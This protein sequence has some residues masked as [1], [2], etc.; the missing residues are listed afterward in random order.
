VRSTAGRFS[1]SQGLLYFAISLAFAYTAVF[2]VIRYLGFNAEMLDLGH[3][4]QAIWSATQGQ[5][6]V[7]TYINGPASDLAKQ[8]EFIYFLLVPFYALLPSPI[9]LLVLQAGLF[10][11]GAIPLYRLA[12]R[13]LGSP[14][15]ALLLAVIYLVYPVALTAVLFDIH[16]D[17]LAMPLVLFALEAQDRRSKWAYLFWLVLAVSC[18]FY[19]AAPAMALGAVLWFKGDRRFAYATWAAALSWVFFVLLFRH[20]VLS[21]D[22]FVAEAQTINGYLNFYF[23]NPATM[24]ATMPLRILGLVVS[25]APALILGRRALLWMAPGL[26][27]VMAVFVSNGPND[28]Y[29]YNS[30][31]YA[32]VVPFLAAGMVHGA[33]A[34]QARSTGA[35]T[36]KAP[37]WKND[38]LFTLLLVGLFSVVFVP[39]PQSLLARA[40]G[41]QNS[42]FSVTPRDSFVDSWLEDFVPEGAAVLAD[43][44]LAPHLA[45]REVL[46]SNYYTDGPS[47]PD[48]R[49]LECMLA[50]V[51][52]VVLDSFSIYARTNPGMIRAILES[53]DF[54]LSESRDGLLLFGRKKSG[55]DQHVEVIPLS[56][57][58][59]P[60]AIFEGRIGLVH[61]SMEALGG[62]RYRLRFDWL[63]LEPLGDKP[64]MMA[65]TRIQGVKDAR[66]V[67]LP[68]FA[69]LPT[70]GWPASNA[71]MLREELEIRV[72]AEAGPGRYPLWLAW[73]DATGPFIE[74]TD[75][76]SRIG[77]EV[78]I[79]YLQIH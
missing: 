22:L 77:Q 76:R 14:R 68:T 54:Y 64:P 34:L 15:Y 23:G 58:Q 25:L 55:I 30:H 35:G 48:V 37:S 27:V 56:R 73:Y 42:A 21:P 60:E 72:P 7:Y 65:V 51:D 69:I 11:A 2:S 47:Y 36:S 43:S 52:Y 31:H 70:K 13:R 3:M 5:P 71:E 10:A 29:N 57:P 9:T 74:Q 44:Y 33:V 49:Q 16:G 24:L 67:H 66:I 79:G 26:V 19:V 59:A 62:D 39:T 17:T 32:L 41:I 28:V 53:P 20:F 75:R 45:N 12:L 61:H 46:Y 63:A 50:D 6:L 18:K 38:L 4:S 78:R 8:G 1:W 40:L